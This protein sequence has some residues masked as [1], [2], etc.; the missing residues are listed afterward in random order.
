MLEK[1][2]NTTPDGP[3]LINT[4]TYN[5]SGSVN[6]SIKKVLSPTRY[7]IT[8]IEVLD[9]GT[10]NL[11]TSPD[12]GLPVQDNLIAHDPSLSKTYFINAEPKDISLNTLFPSNSNSVYS[13]EVISNNKLN[14]KPNYKKLYKFL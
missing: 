10:M 5:L 14:F 1:I 11:K 8:E 3:T 9:N 13:L 4:K 6:F 7:N 2:K 12:H